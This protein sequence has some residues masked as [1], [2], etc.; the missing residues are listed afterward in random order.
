MI[1]LLNSIIFN[2]PNLGCNCHISVHRLHFL[3]LAKYHD[4]VYN[5][6]LSLY[7]FLL[8]SPLNNHRR[9]FKRNEFYTP[10]ILTVNDVLIF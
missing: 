3:S 10:D 6:N 1:Q 5:D 8:E 4:F 9:G 7:S 2:L